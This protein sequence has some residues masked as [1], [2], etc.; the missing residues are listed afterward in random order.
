[1]RNKIEYIVGMLILTLGI[2]LI[3]I[4]DVG[5]SPWD[6]VSLGFVQIYGL[7]LGQWTFIVGVILVLIT[8][9]I[10]SSLIR[11]KVN[12]QILTFFFFSLLIITFIIGI[13]SKLFI[14]PL[15]LT[16]VIF[17]YLSFKNKLKIRYTSILAGLLTGIFIEMWIKLIGEY[18]PSGIITCIV[19]I[20]VLALGIATYTRVD[21]APNPIDNFMV[22]LVDTF[23]LTISKAKIITD[24]IG[25]SIGLVIGGPI[26]I[27]T[28]LIV[29]LTGP[30]VG[31]FTRFY[32][33]L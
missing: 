18:I 20:I 26:G 11:T 13:S 29:I 15:I 19:G 32:K 2:C 6:S 7:N 21:I 31:F 22:T 24:I 3:V 9:L 5:T 10:Q 30:L 28:V 23:D 4:A 17:I 14:Y 8:S 1:M 27:G 16:I 33:H 12:N 25:I